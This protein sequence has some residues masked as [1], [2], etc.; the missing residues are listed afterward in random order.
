M[1]RSESSIISNKRHKSVYIALFVIY[2]S[3][4]IFPA[5]HMSA[6]YRVLSVIGIFS[7]MLIKKNGKML[8]DKKAFLFCIF[9]VGLQTI[10]IVCHG[11]DITS[12]LFLILSIISA[13]LITTAI[14]EMDFLQGC[15]I[16]V[17][18]ISVGSI[19]FFVLG[20]VYPYYV[21]RIPSVFLQ[22][23]RWDNA[24]TL[25]GSFV[26]RNRSLFT[27]Y[28]SFGIFSEP[29]QFQIFLS[30]GLIIELFFVERPNWKLLL[31]LFG[32]IVSCSSTNGYIVAILIIIAYLIDNNSLKNRVQRRFRKILIFVLTIGVF[33][34][35]VVDSAFI[36]EIIQ[37]V[38]GKVTGLTAVYN[39]TEKGTSLERIR[40]F[41]TAL[42]IW[43]QHPI[44]G[45]GY[46]G[47]RAYVKQLSDT[48]FIM[49]CSPLNWLARYGTVYGVC[50]NTCY[51]MAFAWKPKRMTSRLV[52]IFALFSMIS[53]QAVTADIFIWVLII[54]G[55][56]N[57]FNK[58]KIHTQIENEV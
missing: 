45:Y 32:G 54:Y 31:V 20:L 29:G 3:N 1:N 37:S 14:S 17:C 53:A 35:I 38:M 47:M 12:D 46:V 16:A 4:G 39:Y 48:G 11:I 24:Y 25:L 51:C 10:T 30:L 49:T 28:R 13:L 58:R 15:R 50:A 7:I 36:S 42:S 33:A 18:I 43:L 23:T 26:V 19:I 57:I 27:Y 8:L 52:L 22:T 21:S 34:L 56:M 6:L 2:M 44:E 5:V 40:A 41:D 55:F 9:M